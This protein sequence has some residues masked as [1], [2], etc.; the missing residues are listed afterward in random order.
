[1]SPLLLLLAAVASSPSPRSATVPFSLDHNRII[2]E[3]ELVGPHGVRR[4]VPA[5]VDTGNPFLILGESLARELGLELPPSEELGSGHSAEL[6]GPAP[7]IRVGGLAL[8][9]T[10]IGTRIRRGRRVMPGIPAE[11]TLPATALRGRRVVFDYPARRLTVSDPGPDRP[12]GVAIPCRVNAETGLF[13]I[14]A[15]LDGE[16][17]SRPPVCCSACRAWGSAP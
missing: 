2:V 11:A 15:T 4:T 17:V 1:V 16:A 3:L 7:G 14:T 5:W 10:G 9:V 12:R 6:D 13:L 8:D